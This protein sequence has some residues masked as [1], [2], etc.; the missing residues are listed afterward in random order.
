MPLYFQGKYAHAE[1]IQRDVLGVER[2]VLGAEHPNTL[3][4][5]NNLA[6]SLSRQGRYADAEVIQCAVLG[7]LMRVLGAEAA[8]EHAY[9]FGQSGYVPRNPRQICRRRANPA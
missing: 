5:A 6:E 2:H 7:V 3:M 9:E 4:R 1:R 8:P